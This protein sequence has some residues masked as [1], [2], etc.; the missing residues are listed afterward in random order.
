MRKGEPGS[1]N[2]EKIEGEKVK[3]KWEGGL[4]K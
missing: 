3:L 2:G 1:G 4:K